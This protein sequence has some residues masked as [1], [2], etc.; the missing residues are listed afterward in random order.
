MNINNTK[1]ETEDLPLV[2]ILCQAYNHEP[3][4]RQCLDG[5]M[6]QETNFRFEVLIHDDAS[7]DNTANIIRE[8]EAKYPGII[9]PIY[10]TENQFSQGKK[11]LSK[12]QIPRAQRKYIAICEGDDY[13]T[14]PYKLQK[15]IDFL[16]KN[17]EYGLIYSKVKCFNQSKNK[18]ERSLWGGPFTQFEDLIKRNTIPTLTT[19][20]RNNLAKKYIEEF[21]PETQKWKLGDYPI[22]L[23]I[24]L[25]SKIYFFNEISG[26]YRISNNSIS[27]NTNIDKQELYI[28][29]IYAVKKKLLEL[30][31]K[32][33]DENLINEELLECLGTNA[34]LMNNRGLAYDYFSQIRKLTL[35]NIIKK[36]ISKSYLLNFLYIKTFS[37]S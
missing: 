5:I 17:A 11:V 8:Y 19:V 9:M 31:N 27:H 15:Q 13:W 1:K 37:A 30:S 36:I 26:V 21:K 16:E 34:L 32:E 12:I 10:Q 29:S 20:L 28:K 23:Y 6:M 14:D 7:T 24:A 33:F 18:F 25:K 22:W 35:K 4:I 2:S 3:Y